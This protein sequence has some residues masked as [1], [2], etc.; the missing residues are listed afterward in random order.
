MLPAEPREACRHRARRARRDRR[1][2]GRVLEDVLRRDALRPQ[3]RRDDGRH[4]S[5]RDGQ[6]DGGPR[7][8]RDGR[9]RRRAHG[10]KKTLLVAVQLLLE[11]GRA[12]RDAGGRRL[13]ILSQAR[14]RPPGVAD[15]RHHPPRLGP[16]GGL[17]V[18]DRR[19]PRVP[20]LRPRLGASRALRRCRRVGRGSR[21]ATRDALRVARRDRGDAPRRAQGLRRRGQGRRGAPLPERDLRPRARGGGLPVGGRQSLGRGPRGLLRAARVARRRRRQ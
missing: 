13:G 6:G 19:G 10:E 21:R 8:G 18:D 9:E 20:P 12:A 15:A 14:R 4:A 7:A 3:A 17:G 16:R 1:R 5:R 2:D 11:G